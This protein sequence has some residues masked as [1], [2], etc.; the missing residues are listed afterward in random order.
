MIVCLCRGVSDREIDEA[1]RRG[2]RSVDEVSREC[3]GAGDCCGTCRP[4]I[5]DHIFPRQRCRAA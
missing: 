4:L 5:E 2:A 1:V 3:A